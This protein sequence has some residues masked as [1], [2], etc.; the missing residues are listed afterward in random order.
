MLEF[1]AKGQ[2]QTLDKPAGPGGGFS[3]TYKILAI[4]GFCLALLIVTATTAIVQI[5]SIGSEVHEIAAEDIPLTQALTKVTVHQL[6]QA[7]NFERAVRYGEEMQLNPK[8]AEGF[9]KAKAHF[10]ELA[11]Q[12]DG[13]IKAAEKQAGHAAEVAGSE[14]A[15]TEFRSVLERLIKIE[16]AHASYDMHAEEAFALLGRGDVLGA[17]TL[18][19]GIQVEEEALD[20]ELEAL[21]YEV[22]SFTA[23]SALAAEAHEIFALKALIALSVIATLAGI[24]LSIFF[25]RRFVTGPLISLTEVVGELAA[26]NS[27]VE[28]QGLERGDEIGRMARAMVQFREAG[29]NAQRLAQMVED[30]PMG[31]MQCD[32]KS[33]EIT[34]LNKFSRETLKTLEQYLPVK[35]DQLMGQCIDVFHKDPAHQRGILAD[36][37][38]L[39]HNAQIDVGPE[40]LDL[41]VTPIMDPKGDYVGPMLTWS[42][43]T[44]KAKADAEAARLAQMV[45]DMPMGVMQ[46]DPKS[47]EITYLN[48]FSRETLKT[49]E[50]YL[51]VTADQL[52]GQ[53][54]DVFHKNPAHQRS[55]L[56]NPKNL[57]H[58]AQIDVGPEILDLLVTPIV[59]KQG[60]Y[61][62]PMLTWSV[63]TEK[64]KADAEA[65]RLA[66]MVEDMPVGV[67]TC[68]PKTL[69][70]NYLNAFS[71]ETLTT[72]EQHLPVKADQ[73]LGQCIDIFHKNPA[74]QRGILADPK[75]L[76]HRGR[77]QVG[78][79][80]LDLLISPISDTNGAY[81]GPMLTWSVISDKV[82]LA[83]DFEANVGKVVEAVSAA[84]TEMQ[85]TAQ[86]MSATAEETS[87]QASAAAAGV[88]EATT[89][90]QTVASAAEELSSSITEVSRQVGESA[91]VARNAVEEASR[92]NTQVEGLVEAAQKIGEVVSL[93]SDIAEQTNLLA[94]NATIEAARAGEAGKGFAVVASEVK[95]LAN[96]TAKATEEISTQIGAIQG[97]TGDAAQAIKGIGET[98]QKVDEIA[99]SIASAVEEQSAATQEIARNAQQAAS[100]TNEVSSNVT[101]VTQA[102]GET[103]SASNQVLEAAKGL[104]KQSTDLSGQIDR[105]LKSLNAA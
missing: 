2:G 50:Q 52:M 98:I 64:A 41:L 73:M 67:M 54:I 43:I 13:E 77:I 42:V 75:N 28:I 104:A 92:T 86:S 29:A 56:A 11:H 93:I 4:V 1:H 48:K 72:I 96:Q 87:R 70:I 15:R 12:V 68:D 83:D 59:D 5:A 51:P 89:N 26:G 65:A 90:V 20:K 53:C 37:S 8:A 45:E 38:N 99:S 40:T 97:A 46:C 60:G 74:H 105:F 44:E 27:E 23:A 103:G 30:M 94:L 61:I 101:G 35:A 19:E 17:L 78:P 3:I 95:S 80:Y 57:P 24:A 14:A 84:S 25:V 100:G 71:R 88:E 18:V 58:S 47:F 85:S 82:R 62:G 36:P 6:E 34:Y 76:P 63:V 33:F 22:G 39:P 55:I 7:V 16:K 91:T 66:Q 79:E 9:A 49:L 69:E 21:L 32:P 81:I 10:L 102:A 31:V